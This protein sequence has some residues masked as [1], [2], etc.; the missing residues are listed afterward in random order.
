MIRTPCKHALTSLT[1][2]LHKDGSQPEGCRST[3]MSLQDARQASWPAT[4]KRCPV[5]RTQ[6]H[7]HTATCRRRR[8]GSSPTHPQ[9]ANP[10]GPPTRSHPRRC[11]GTQARARPGSLD[12]ATSTL[13]IPSLTIFTYNQ[14]K[15]GSP[16]SF[17]LAAAFIHCEGSV[18]P[19]A[20][21]L[22][23]HIIFFST[24]RG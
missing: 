12:E 18:K 1:G 22:W 21:G 11:P 24:T 20:T 19:P 8:H 14:A 13:Y 7:G 4:S 6:R 23:Y 2:T 16:L 5:R 15:H 10:T 3:H 17:L 9:P